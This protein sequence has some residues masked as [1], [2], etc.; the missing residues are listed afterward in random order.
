MANSNRRGAAIEGAMPSMIVKASQQVSGVTVS[1]YRTPTNPFTV[2]A[3]TQ[4]IVDYSDQCK[5]IPNAKP[6][7]LIE[8][9]QGVT[10]SRQSI[11]RTGK[12]ASFGPIAKANL[13]AAPD[14]SGFF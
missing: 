11:N 6:T 5:I 13:G 8:A 10:T 2:R 12:A 14:E 4:Y 1:R 7:A 9:T 3:M